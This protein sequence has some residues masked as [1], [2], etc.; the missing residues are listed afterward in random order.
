MKPYLIELLSAKRQIS[1]GR[2][3]G[4]VDHDMKT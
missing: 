4:D 3:V 2:N 1:I